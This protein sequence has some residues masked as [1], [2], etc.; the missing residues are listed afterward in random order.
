M[1]EAETSRL[2]PDDYGRGD[3]TTNLQNTNPLSRRAVMK[4]IV[5][6]HSAYLEI[7]GVQP[8]PVGIEL[9][10]KSAVLGRSPDCEIPLPVTE[11]SRHHA[12]ISYQNE[13]YHVE[14]LDS[15]NGTMVNGVSIKKCVLR[16][17][18]QIQI[19]EITIIFVEERTRQS[20]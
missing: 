13:E 11:V 17:N 7:N 9:H 20:K 3:S 12:R 6:H 10:E 8:K 1:N 4:H 18:D 5:F 16:N 15:T 2:S 19:G 14:D